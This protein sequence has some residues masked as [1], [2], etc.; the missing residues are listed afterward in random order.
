MTGASILEVH[1]G[2]LGNGCLAIIM[3]N[4]RFDLFSNDLL[5]DN[6]PSLIFER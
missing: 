3:V 5:D 6:R 4:F 2:S 1:Q